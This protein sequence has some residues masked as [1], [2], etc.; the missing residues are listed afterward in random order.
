MGNKNRVNWYYGFHLY[1][2]ET[3][4]YFHCSFD[5]SFGITRE[6]LL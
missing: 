3:P 5:S 2:L 6:K 4:S 1:L